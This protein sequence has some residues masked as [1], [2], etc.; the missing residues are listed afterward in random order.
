MLW[1][2]IGV[3]AFTAFLFV[4]GNVGPK[5]R[6]HEA[7]WNPFR[8][9]RAD[10][11]SLFQEKAETS[12]R[13]AL[14]PRGVHL[15]NYERRPITASSVAVDITARISDTPLTIG[16]YIDG[17]WI[18]GPGID[19]RFEDE[20]A[21]TPDDLV[22]EFTDKLVALVESHREAPSANKDLDL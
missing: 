14:E 12:L 8:Q 15:V 6:R 21:P 17:A 11:T 10:G 1:V 18:S 16:I 13:E 19:E 20:G 7:A 2:L 22:R 5:R 3:V 4:N 9:A